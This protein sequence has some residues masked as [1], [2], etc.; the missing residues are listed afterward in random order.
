M[1]K[2]TIYTL[3][4]VIILG[5]VSIA[6]YLYSVVYVGGMGSDLSVLYQK[7][8]ELKGEESSL[9]SIKRVAENAD[10]RNTEISKYIVPVEDEGS[11]S[12]VKTMESIADKYGL[13]YNTNTIE[14][15]PD[16]S[17]SKI[18]KEYLSIG[19]SLSGSNDAI[20]SFVKKLDSVPFNIKVKSFSLTRVSSTLGVPVVGGPVLSNGEQLD[21]KI[22]VIKEK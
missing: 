18:N 15:V 1:L 9:N 8:D 10:Q 11:I 14:I 7:S 3:I 22:L 19:M 17:L 12:F 20:S 2:S 4:L 13:K 6:G 16:D 5:L 21:C